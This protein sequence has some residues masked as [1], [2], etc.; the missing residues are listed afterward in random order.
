MKRDFLGGKKS[1]VRLLLILLSIALLVYYV[2]DSEQYTLLFA[3]VLAAL[4]FGKYIYDTYKD[5][6]DEE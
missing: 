5:P 6:D 1:K 4:V 2:F 3:V